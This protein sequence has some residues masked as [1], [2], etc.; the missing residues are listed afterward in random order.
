[1]ENDQILISV[2]DKLGIGQECTAF[3]Q[4]VITFIN[5]VFSILNQIGVH[6]KDSM[7][8]EGEET[9]VDI[10]DENAIVLDMIKTYVYLKVRILFDPPTNSTHL[11]SIN[12]VSNEYEWRINLEVEGGSDETELLDDGPPRTSRRPRNE[13]GS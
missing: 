8:I 3:D 13:M 5:S 11:E 1:M 12:A 9:W 10:F 7:F 2:K 4:D 6:F